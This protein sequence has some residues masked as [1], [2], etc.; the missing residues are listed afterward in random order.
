MHSECTPVEILCHLADLAFF[1]I[2]PVVMGV[3]TKALAELQVWF[4]SYSAQ[5]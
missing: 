2:K 1:R 3:Y 4:Y 5:W